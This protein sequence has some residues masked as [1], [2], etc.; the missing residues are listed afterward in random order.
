MEYTAFGDTPASRCVYY[1]QVCDLPATIDPPHLGRIIMRADF[2]WALMMPFPLGQ[3][4]KAHMQRE[5]RDIGPILSH[6]RSSRWSYLV[7]PDLP[8]DDYLFAKMFR[9]NV[10]VV[11]TGGTIALPSPADQHV[12]FRCWIESPRCTFRPSGLVVVDAIRACAGSGRS[13]MVTRA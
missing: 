12:E 4:V 7:R 13:P 11:R 5:D 1:R 8:D 2:I 10:S 6:P 9:L 3:A